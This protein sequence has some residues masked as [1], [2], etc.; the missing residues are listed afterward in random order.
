MECIA[1]C[2]CRVVSRV[3][4]DLNPRFSMVIDAFVGTALVVAGWRINISDDIK[5]S[6]FVFTIFFTYTVYFSFQL[7]RW[8]LQSR[9]GDFSKIRLCRNHV[10]G[11]CDCLLDWSVCRIHRLFARV[12]YAVCS[13]LCSIARE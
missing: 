8:L 1:T 12:S 11:A 5:M 9:F 4:S 10:Y 7:Y 13:K 2:M 3:L 6:Q